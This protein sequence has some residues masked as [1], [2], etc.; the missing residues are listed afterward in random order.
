MQDLALDI[1]QYAFSQQPGYLNQLCNTQRTFSSRAVE[2][3]GEIAG[4]G[5]GRGEGFAEVDE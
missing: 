1:S 5:V 2:F 4:E 3:K